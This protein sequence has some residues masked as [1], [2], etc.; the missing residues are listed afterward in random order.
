MIDRGPDGF[1]VAWE[2]DRDKDG[3][4]LFLRHLGSELDPIGP[5][6]RATDFAPSRGHKP[7]LRL[8]SIAVA[9]NAIYVAYRLDRDPQHTIERIRIPL[10]TPEL[11]K[12]LD[13]VTGA[14]RDRVIGDVKLMS[15]DKVSGDAPSIACGLEGCFLAWHAEPGG[16][17]Y[18]AMIDPVKGNLL[19]HKKLT[20][21]GGRPSHAVSDGQV[22]VAYYE[23]GRVRMRILT[24]DVPDTSGISILT[25]V[26]GDQ[27]R[28]SLAG[29]KQ[30]GE[31]LLA[32]QEAEDR[33][34]EA[35]AARVSCK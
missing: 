24:R 35:Y 11:K 20:P 5:E 29:G 22:A 31:W 17:A 28:P 2:D 26:N 32:W 16:G 30:K 3:D 12:G 7:Q 19:W 34:V 8:P 25:K 9:S 15:E 10:S 33:H 4:D 21:Q 13:D 23:Q 1:W 27:P 6:I 18:A 14:R